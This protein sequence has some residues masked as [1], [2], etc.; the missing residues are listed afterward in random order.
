MIVKATEGR[1]TEPP[2]SGNTHVGEEMRG[3]T[4]LEVVRS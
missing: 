1:E 3:Q 4:G 2:K